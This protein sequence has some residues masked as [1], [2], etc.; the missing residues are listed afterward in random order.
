MKFR[1]Y[2]VVIIGDT[3]GIINEI[4]KISETEPSHIDGK[5]LYIATF[6]SAL[7]PNEIKHTLIADNRNF[8]LFELDEQ[9]SGFNIMKE[10]IHE[11]LFGFLKSFNRSKLDS[12]SDM[13]LNDIKMTSET[14]TNRTEWKAPTSKK[15]HE[16][17]PKVKKITEV[18]IGQMTKKEKEKMLNEIIDNGLENLTENDR[19]LLELLAK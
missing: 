2:C 16:V 15:R 14:A 3:M 8:L 1:A 10:D 9:T 7:S 18:E 19:K 17:K 11:G 5:G 6:V 13:L 12:M 4:K